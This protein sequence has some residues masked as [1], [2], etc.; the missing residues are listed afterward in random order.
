VA[1]RT[2]PYFAQNDDL[3]PTGHRSAHFETIDEARVWLAANGG[4]TVK[5]RGGRGHHYYDMLRVPACE[6]AREDG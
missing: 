2:T 1:N 3:T 5:L 6:P 4:G